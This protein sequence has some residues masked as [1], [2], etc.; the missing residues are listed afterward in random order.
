MYLSTIQKE[1]LELIINERLSRMDKNIHSIDDTEDKVSA[2]QRTNSER[3]AL[4]DI[5]NKL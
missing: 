4:T 5:L 2:I 3:E 1:W